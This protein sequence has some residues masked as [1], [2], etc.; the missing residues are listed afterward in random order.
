M[1]RSPTLPPATVA[2]SDLNPVVSSNLKDAGNRPIDHY[3]NKLS[4]FRF[5]L[6]QKCLPI[7][8]KETEI[9]TKLQTKI[10]TPTLDFYFAWS[11]NLA[12]H[13]FYVLMLPLPTWFG[14][15]PI[16]R[17]LVYVL[18]FGIY[19]TGNFKDFMCLPRPRSPPL[20][21]ITMSSY[22]AQEYGW[23]LSHSANATAVTLILYRKLFEIRD[24]LSEATFIALSIGFFIYY[25]SLIFGRLYCGMHGFFDI[26]FG[27][28]IGLA[29]FL[30]RVFYG[31]AWDAWL[32]QSPRND[33]IIG[34]LTTLAIILGGYVFL[35]HIHSE[36]VDDCPC[37]DDSVAFVG[38]LIGLDL[39][40]WA[41]Y[42][43]DYL[44][45]RNPYQHPLITEYSFQKLGLSYSIIRFVLG[46]GLVVVWKAVSKPVIFTI[47]PPVYKFIGIYLPRRNYE[48][49]AFTNKTT[50]QIR[51]Q[52]LSNMK[53]E[54]IGGEINNLIRDV[55]DHDKKD[56]I[57][58]ENDIDVYEILDYES[59]K[60]NHRKQDDKVGGKEDSASEKIEEPPK[61]SGVFK[62][63]YDVEIIGRLIVYAG[64][65]IVSIWGFIFV[66]EFLHLTPY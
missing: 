32:L 26:L 60:L 14:G 64:I 46:V 21:R 20:H 2:E 54:T 19:I 3:K 34:C 35:I 48:A 40:H 28:L 49:T 50:R 23:P 7:V 63:R 39:S 30:F 29:M 53:H 42:L 13:T 10:R 9:L 43:S 5:N 51:S 16:L 25:F 56:E 1:S 31:E 66:T 4:K 44:V 62:P 8:R 36:P 27:S 24:Q 37:F 41:C 58:P 18:G 65:S 61:L 55:M 6:R 11:A 22:T 15:G 57:G 12:S 52:S 33:S 17:D 38:V 47:L 59:S 45:T